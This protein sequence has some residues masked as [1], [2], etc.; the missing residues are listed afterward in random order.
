MFITFEGID[1]S[2]KTTQGKLLKERLEA[3]GYKVL[4][5]REPGGTKVAESIRSLLLH[6][7]EK[8]EPMTEVFLYCAARNEHLEKIIIP[9]LNE[10]Y[11]V[12]SDRYY[13]STLAYQ[14]FGRDLGIEEMKKIN[15][16]FINTCPPDLTFF[17]D[18]DMKDFEERLEGQEL[19]RMEKEGTAFMEKVREGY[20]QLLLE[21]GD[22]IKKIS[23]TGDIKEVSDKIFLLVK[24]GLD[25]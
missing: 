13:D 21:E 9:A 17:L 6:L 16:H 10:G 2:G 4:L 22:R 23:S 12:I 7:D 25:A 5:T 8:I 24:E 19:D 1:G 20:L 18:I 15:W 11:I 3:L 14:G